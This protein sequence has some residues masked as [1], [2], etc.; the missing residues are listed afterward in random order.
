MREIKFRAYGPNLK[1]MW[2]WDEIKHVS[3]MDLILVGEKIVMQYTGL[4]DKNGVDIYEGDLITNGSGRIA[5]VK[6]LNVAGM[7][8]CE[9][10]KIA[11]ND[12]SDGFKNNCWPISVEVIGNIHENPELIGKTN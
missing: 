3:L 12:N 6:W 2:E 4:K 1:H 9:P 7:W 11:R 10:V 8:D 5:Q